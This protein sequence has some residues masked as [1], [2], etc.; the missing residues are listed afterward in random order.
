MLM[1][2][3]KTGRSLRGAISV[4]GD[5][6]IAH[7][8]LM[9]G[10]IAEGDSVIHGMPLSGDVLTTR[11]CM[12]TLGVQISDPDADGRVVVEGRGTEGL[13]TPLAPLDCRNSGTTARLLCGLLSAQ[14]FSA[15]LDGDKSLR[16][17][18]MARVVD[19]LRDMGARIDYLAD[20]N[21]LPLRVE[22]GLLP[23]TLHKPEVASAQVK[24]ALLLASLAAG[25]GCRLLEPVQTRNH[26]ELMLAHMGS[27]LTLV[28]GIVELPPGARISG[29]EF[30]LPGD[31]SSASFLIAAAVLL[32][33]SD[34]KCLN[35][36]V[37]QGRLGFID[38][39]QEMGADIT[40]EN[41]RFVGGEPVAD[42]HVRHSALKGTTVRGSRIPRIIDELPLLALVASQAAG[43]TLIR[44][45]AE[46]RLKESDRIESTAAMLAALGISCET[47][48][49]GFRISG[50]QRVKGGRVD[51]RGDHRIAMSAVV[52]SLLS[53]DPVET[54]DEECIAVSYPG[55][56]E[57]IMRLVD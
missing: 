28:D 39:L 16:R 54:S 23:F 37:N 22:G 27:G 5:K 56:R 46:L 48:A 38:T 35:I 47:H 25:S 40:L 52:A 17:R 30:E 6:S 10:G 43:S 21:R 51:S 49:D 3:Q 26:T 13:K 12:R 14:R 8:A 50:P 36:G 55:F 31:I 20:T 9:L 44:D 42:I 7:R 18:P 32:P 1:H 4:P 24:S 41:Q 53:A 29:R 15:T 57:E 11:D 19:P 34:L 45:A 2:P 33:G